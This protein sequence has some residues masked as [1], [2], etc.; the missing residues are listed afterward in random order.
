[1]KVKYLKEIRKDVCGEVLLFSPSGKT[2]RYRKEL[3]G[4]TNELKTLAAISEAAEAVVVVPFD[5]DN[6]GIIK[7]SVGVFDKGKLSGI[8]DM[9]VTYEDSPYMPG[10]SGSLY[11]T[12]FGKIAVAVGDD[13]YSYELMRSFAICGAE[14]IISVRTGKSDMDGIVLRAFSYLLGIPFVSVTPDG[15]TATDHKGDV[16]VK[17]DREEEFSVCSATEFHLK[18]SKTRFNGRK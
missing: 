15:V 1:M 18:I 5:T 9:T 8:S 14:A 7:H 6:Y 3:S 17:T 13:L 2:V 10:V 11:D 12:S 4:E 16:T